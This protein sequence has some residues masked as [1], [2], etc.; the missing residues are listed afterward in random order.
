MRRKVDIEIE[1]E[2]HI[3]PNQWVGRAYLGDSYFLLEF[4]HGKSEEEA[5]KSM[6]NVTANTLTTN[7]LLYTFDPD[8]DESY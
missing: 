3:M 4:V 8:A 2:E 6:V 7:T 5:F 1:V